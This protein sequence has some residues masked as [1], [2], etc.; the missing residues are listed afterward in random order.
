MSGP[1][2]VLHPESV[3][4]PHPE[5]HLTYYLFTRLITRVERRRDYTRDYTR[6]IGGP[7]NPDA[8]YN[9]TRYNAS[10]RA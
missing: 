6:F 7:S 5:K 4:Q 1:K 9:V 8:S 3:L 2:E 10:R